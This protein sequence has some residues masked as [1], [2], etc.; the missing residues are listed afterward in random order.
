MSETRFCCHCAGELRKE[1]TT[2]GLGFYNVPI[3]IKNVKV[4]VCSNCKVRHFDAALL[5][6]IVKLA[7]ELRQTSDELGL[8]IKNVEIEFEM[9]KE[10]NKDVYKKV[11]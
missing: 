1:S 9:E 5:D 2:V 6:L 4:D 10:D 8:K 11:E 7:R 3:W